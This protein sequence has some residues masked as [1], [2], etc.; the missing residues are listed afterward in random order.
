MIQIIT[1]NNF[2]IDD[3]FVVSKFSDFQSMNDFDVNIIDLNTTKIWNNKVSNRN[4]SENKS[5]RDIE[6]FLNLEKQISNTSK[7]VIIILPQDLEFSWNVYD[8][9]YSTPLRNII[10]TI[11]S[12]IRVLFDFNIKT[13]DINY[14]KT[15]TNVNSNEYTSNFTFK[16]NLNN[17]W[18][19]L[20]SSIIG[21]EPTTIKLNNKQ[22]I[23]TTLKL[24]SN[25]NIID[26]LYEIEYFNAELIEEPNWVNEINVLD[27][28]KHISSINI[29]NEKINQLL[30]L[31]E[32][33]NRILLR[34]KQYKSILYTSGDQLSETVFMI[35]SEILKYDLSGFKDK[36]NEDIKF[37]IEGITYIGEIKGVSSNV[38]STNLAQLDNHFSSF[39]E[40]Y[41]QYNEENVRKLL[42]INH[43]REKKLSERDPVDKKQIDLA[44][45]K[46]SCLIIETKVLLKIFDKYKSEKISREEFISLIRDNVGILEYN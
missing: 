31:N 43:Q 18:E 19:V 5:I 10:Q 41:P 14:G 26:L 6:Q 38:K 3:Q 11:N 7:L 33:S 35:F 39:L 8:S 24:E 34:N 46:Y 20:T 29:N 9:S 30:K 16:I 22:L 44:R 15:K 4:A 12:S 36:K 37:E 2:E 42:I 45:N 28:D 32:E 13:L 1:Y 23:Y 21:K 17:W 40:T 27:D 25:K